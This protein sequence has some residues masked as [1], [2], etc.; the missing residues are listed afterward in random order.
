M[1]PTDQIFFVFLF[2]L[3]NRYEVLR[4]FNRTAAANRV[5]SSS[6]DWTLI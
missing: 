3:L 5:E 1:S 6:V 2:V 4:I